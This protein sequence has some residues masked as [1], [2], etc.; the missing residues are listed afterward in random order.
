MTTIV[1]L[2]GPQ[3][4]LYCEA[5]DSADPAAYLRNDAIDWLPQDRARVAEALGLACP[6][7]VGRGTGRSC[8]MCGLPIPDDLCRDPGD[9][10]ELPGTV[11]DG[12]PFPIATAGAR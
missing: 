1:D 11:V 10:S 4:A 7:C 2:S 5:R 3:Q 9:L 8:C 12:W 6:G